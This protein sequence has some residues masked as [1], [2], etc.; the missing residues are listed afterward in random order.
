MLGLLIKREIRLL[1]RRKAELLNPLFF[2]LVVTT[3]FP[4]GISPE[5]KVLSTLAPGVLWVCVLLSLL[6]SLDVLY[7]EDFD[8]G[9]LVQLLMSGASAANIV[10]AKS[11]ANWLFCALPLIVMSPLLSVMLH[12][13]SDALGAL[14][15]SLLA[16]TPV[17]CLLGAIGMSLTVGLRRGGILLVLLVLP[18]YI[19]VLILG[20]MLVSAASMGH[21]YLPLLLLL[22]AASVM[23]VSLAPWA[24]GAALKVSVSE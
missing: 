8:D 17:L 13:P 23:S 18:L 16:G 11:I 24:A 15:A 9:S 2:F 1:L 22:I 21:S 12:L 19:P 4:L 7:R 6:L 3:M 14:I 20:T 10:L 5:A